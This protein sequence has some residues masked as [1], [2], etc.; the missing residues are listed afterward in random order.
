MVRVVQNPNL[1]DARSP[2]HGI[3]PLPALGRDGACLSVVI[4]DGSRKR[5]DPGPEYPG[6]ST[7][8]PLFAVPALRAIPGDPTSPPSGARGCGAG[9]RGP[10][11]NSDDETLARCTNLPIAQAAYQAGAKMYPQDLIELRQGVRI[12]EQSK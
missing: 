8:H 2:P 6:A 7:C 4:P 5:A 12:V 3:Y 1:S 9:A 11:S 10:S